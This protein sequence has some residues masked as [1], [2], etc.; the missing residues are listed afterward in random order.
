MNKYF[1]LLLIFIG[2]GLANA[3][4]FWLLPKKFKYKTGDVMVLD[5]MVGENFEGEF[6]D[7]DRHKVEKITLY[8]RL[9]TIDLTGKEKKEMGSNLEYTFNNVGTQMVALESNNAYIE[10]NP[11]KFNAYLK[12]DGLEY[13]LE[14][15]KKLGEEFQTSRE[16]YRRYA[17]LLVQVG[18]RTDDSYKKMAGLKL[19]IMPDQNPYNLKPGDYLN[20]KVYYEGKP[21]QHALVKV[22]NHIGNR[23]FLQNIYTENDG[24]IRFPIS[25]GGAWMV[26]TVKMVR[27]QSDKAEW[28]SMWSSLV[29]GIE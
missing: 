14:E 19:E 26:S 10:L 20:C 29:F 1:V 5:F 3:H 23:V 9:A 27:A 28:Q 13:I 4:E 7:L 8:N 22:W 15:R 2:M 21:E 6:W 25:S 11:E 12:E 16:L 24:S 17:K 18:D